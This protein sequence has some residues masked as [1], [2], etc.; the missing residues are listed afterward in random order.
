[1]DADLV[2]FV[3]I[4]FIEVNPLAIIDQTIGGGIMV[5]NIPWS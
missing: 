3:F 1:M 5:F 2:Q 4:Q